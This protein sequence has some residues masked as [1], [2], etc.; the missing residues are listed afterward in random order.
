[1][2]RQRDKPKA[3]ERKESNM[4]RAE[5]KSK[6]ERFLE[7]SDNRD[8]HGARD[9]RLTEVQGSENHGPRAKDKFMDMVPGMGRLSGKCTQRR[10]DRKTEKGKE[11]VGSKGAGRGSRGWDA[12]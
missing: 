10:R 2:E 8:R 9:R 3:G 12:D 6:T 7:A 5:Q 4:Q 1:M 11:E